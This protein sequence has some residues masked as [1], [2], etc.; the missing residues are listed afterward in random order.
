MTNST[1]TDGRPYLSKLL[2]S[3]LVVLWVGAFCI[4]CQIRQPTPPTAA[5]APAPTASVPA[6]AAKDTRA[7]SPVQ[8]LPGEV[9]PTISRSAREAGPLVTQGDLAGVA[10]LFDPREALAFVEALAA[11]RWGGRQTGSA[12][13]IAVARYI[14]DRFA[15][16]GL[17]PAGTEGYYQSFSAPYAEMI[18]LPT[19][20]I[21]TSA[22]REE[23]AYRRD[24]A[25]AWGGYAGGGVAVGHVFWLGD[26]RQEDYRGLDVAGQIVFCRYSPKED[27]LRQA[28]EHGASGLLL[29]TEDEGRISRLRT[30]REPAYLPTSLPTL[31]VSPRVADA[32]LEGNGYSAQDLSILYKP[33]PLKALARFSIPLREPGEAPARNVMGV[34]PGAN[35][36]LRDKV[37]VLSA[38]YDHLGTD[39]DGTPYLGA[40]DNASGVAV[41]LEI[42]RTWHSAGFYPGCTVLFATWDG[43]EQGLLG[44]RHYIE[45]PRYPLANTIAV[46]TLDMVGLASKG[47]LTIDGSEGALSRQLGAS[48]RM[49]GVTTQKTS[50]GVGSDHE[51]FLKANVPAALL[52]WDDGAV[53]Y[54]HTPDDTP[55]TLQPERLRQAGAIASHTAMVISTVEPQLRDLLATQVEALRAGDTEAYMATLDDR[56]EGLL[57]SARIW[58]TSH[59]LEAFRATTTTLGALE[60]GADSAQVAITVRATEG[61]AGSRVLASYPTRLVRRGTAWKITWPVAEVITDS[62]VI[63][64]I[65]Q[66]TQGDRQWLASTVDT[67]G[68]LNHALG[69]T[70]T[71]PLTMTRNVLHSAL[72]R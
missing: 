8:P 27:L 6:V 34:L 16:L 26:G 29:L 50:G 65:V 23:F 15:A 58:L 4:A 53:P 2:H 5:P 44:S 68:R 28:V 38:H 21:T 69:L 14:A 40:N 1:R 37:L 49:L 55:H 30:Y 25:F 20:V 36:T 47:V 3:M 9:G 11:P 35:P 63:A 42:A 13:G 45:N 71:S 54:Y 61:Q 48:A 57:R 52:I 67:Y 17:Q 70:A 12:G 62:Q 24:Y 43:E 46:L 59:P 41:L 10:Q 32:L 51:L 64:N 39:A 19:L 22:S 60:V 18:A 31:L 72:S 66:P 7:P 56:D 33:L